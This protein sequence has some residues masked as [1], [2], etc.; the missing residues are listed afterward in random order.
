MATTLGYG[1]NGTLVSALN[2]FG[3]TRLMDSR[4]GGGRTTQIAASMVEQRWFDSDTNLEMAWVSQFVAAPFTMAGEIAFGA[5]AQQSATSVNVGLRGKILRLP[6]DLRGNGLQV[7]LTASRSGEI[8]TSATDY[9][10]TGTP[11]AGVP[12]AVNDRIM[13]LGY[14]YPQGG[15]TAAGT[16]TLSADEQNEVT[17]T[18]DILFSATPVPTA[19]IVTLPR[20]RSRGV[21]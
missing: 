11:G 4:S 3:T 9:T 21:L 6:A 13:F 18:E 14:W 20:L 17:F 8:G 12:F 1:T 2:G 10:W 16:A 5:R 19:P 15:T 7:V